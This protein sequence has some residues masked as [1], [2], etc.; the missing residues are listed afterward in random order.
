MKR[1]ISYWNLRI[2][3]PT[4][5]KHMNR[6]PGP[7]VGLHRD[8][9]VVCCNGQPGG[10]LS[11]SEPWIFPVYRGLHPGRWTA[12][13]YRPPIWKGK[14]SSRPSWLCSMLIFR[15]VYY[16][17]IKGV[18]ISHCKDIPTRQ[19]VKVRKFEGG[20]V[21]LQKTD[22]KPK[23]L[24]AEHE[25]NHWKYHLKQTSTR[26]MPTASPHFHQPYHHFKTW[27][28]KIPQKIS[29]DGMYVQNNCYVCPKL[30][31]NNSYFLLWSFFRTQLT[32]RLRN[33]PT[34]GKKHHCFLPS[35]ILTACPWR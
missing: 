25:P 15:G 14:W 16:P 8:Q 11:P 21:E 33:L 3:Q 28:V 9:E 13:T 30:P 26:S 22:L 4:R 10:K 19:P 12:G 2:F 23:F 17:V 31:N 20:T 18:I 6:H 27:M 5:L 7:W 32:L 34:K 24:E 29:E 35:P 1:C